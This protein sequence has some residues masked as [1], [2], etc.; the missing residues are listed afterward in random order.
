MKSAFQENVAVLIDGGFFVKR[1]QQLVWEGAAHDAK[2]V[3][4]TAWRVAEAHAGSDRLHRIF[5][6]DCPAYKN[7][8]QNPVSH[9]QINFGK[10]EQA[11][12]RDELHDELKRKRKVALRL[13]VRHEPPGRGKGWMLKPEKL[14]DLLAGKIAVRDLTEDDVF[15]DLRRKRVDMKIAVDIATLAH[16]RLV[17]RIVLIAGDS[18]FIPAAKLARREGIDFIL[19]PMWN[20]IV[21]DL[22]EHI[23]GTHTP[24]IIP[25]KA[26]PPAGKSES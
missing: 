8:G 24:D 10:T 17:T 23:D 11:K 19:D 5:F 2:T 22:D 25:R 1:Y 6:Y 26:V 18:D 4:E 16:K 13:G 9:R 15:Y 3:A 7:F 14:R 12:F 20:H 21:G